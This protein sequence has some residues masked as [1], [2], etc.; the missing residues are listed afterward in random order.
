MWKHAAVL[1]A[2]AAQPLAI[3]EPVEAHAHR[4]DRRAV[5][6]PRGLFTSRQDEATTRRAALRHLSSPPGL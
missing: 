5:K 6:N 1:P 4:P 3:G 2:R